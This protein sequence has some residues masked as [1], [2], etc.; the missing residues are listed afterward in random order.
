MSH[1]QVLPFEPDLLSQREGAILSQC[2]LGFGHEFLGVSNG[3]LSFLSDVSHMFDAILECWQFLC[4]FDLMGA[5]GV[6]H[7]QFK[8]G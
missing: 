6:S 7:D 4:V 1:R 2:C 3:D 8:W 5:R